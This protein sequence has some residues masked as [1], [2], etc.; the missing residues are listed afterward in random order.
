MLYII[1]HKFLKNYFIKLKFLNVKIFI[2]QYF[3]KNNNNYC[4]KNINNIKIIFKWKK[5]QK[6]YLG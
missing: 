6:L 5:E 2:S 4:Q 3:F 1:F